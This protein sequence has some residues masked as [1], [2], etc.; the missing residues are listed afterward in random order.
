[1]EFKEQIRQIKSDF[2]SLRN[3]EIADTL[4]KAGS[5]YKII[6][7]LQMPQ[8]EQ[9]AAQSGHSAE[10]AEWMWSNDSTRES[11]IF[12]TMVYPIESFD[13]VKADKWAQEAETF[14][15]IDTLCF[16]LVR[17]INGS[18][19]LVHKY[20]EST[21]KKMRYFAF[22]LALNLLILRKIS[23]TDN[24]YSAAKKEVDSSQ[25]MALKRIANQIIQ[26]V[27]FMLE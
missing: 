18:E 1:M 24:L 6:F 26:E 9:I 11:K 15:L 25:T 14:E 5:P 16:R 12:A 10:L 2:F 3:G 19:E 23:N 8:L 27:E 13:L 4:R 17:Y 21:E 20:I 22:R 7:G